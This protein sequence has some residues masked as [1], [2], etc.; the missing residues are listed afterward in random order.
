MP[1]KA[2]MKPALKR[3]D[4]ETIKAIA[5]SSLT[6][7]QLAET[8][9]VS[10]STVKRCRERH[11]TE[12]RGEYAKRLKNPTK[13]KGCGYNIETNRCLICAARRA[14]GHV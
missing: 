3:L 6:A 9:G 7:P 14:G 4:P 2:K 10:V 5:R 12:R 8:Y 1:Y 13:C 11:P